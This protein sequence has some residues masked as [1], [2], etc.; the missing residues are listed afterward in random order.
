[1]ASGPPSLASLFLCSMAGKHHADC[2][3]NLPWPGLLSYA[4]KVCILNFS[5]DKPQRSPGPTDEP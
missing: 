2:N 3:P 1:M 4:E 5:T